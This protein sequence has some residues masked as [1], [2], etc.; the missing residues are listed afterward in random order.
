MWKKIKQ[1]LMGGSTIIGD[2]NVINENSA[3][4]NSGIVARNKVTINGRF[5]VGDV[6]G[7][8][9]T[10]TSD[11]RCKSVT[12]SVSTNTGDIHKG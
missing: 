9:T 5:V 1:H 2:D 7:D 11:I 3:T 12:G 6:S 8:V 10:N 4:V